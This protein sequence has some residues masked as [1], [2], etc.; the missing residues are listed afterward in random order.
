M[1]LTNG[2]ELRTAYRHQYASFASPS[3]E[4]LTRNAARSY[5]SVAHDREQQRRAEIVILAEVATVRDTLAIDGGKAALP[6]EVASLNRW[7]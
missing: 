1:P 2:L 4:M 3:L 6:A 5:R 7:S